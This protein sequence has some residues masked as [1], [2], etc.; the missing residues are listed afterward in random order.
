M[1][2][3]VGLGVILAGVLREAARR[4]DLREVFS[5]LL[6]SSTVA[7][8]ERSSTEVLQAVVDLVE[9]RDRYTRGHSARVAEL[10]AVIGERLGLYPEH[11]RRL[12]Q[13]AVLHDVGK[14]AVP[15]MI[16]NKPGPL[17]AEEFAV[18]AAHTVVGDQLI[19][20]IPALS[21]AR[22]GI[23]WH[24]ERLDG[25]GYP[26][27][28]AGDAIPLEA[29]IIAVADVYD[30]MTSTRAYR[31]GLGEK[32]ALDELRHHAGVK[33]DARAVGA[34]VRHIEAAAASRG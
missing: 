10:S 18:V 9:A 31:P 14:I 19:E 23:R 21:F 5:V 6:A 20:R 4:H 28:L 27:G 22:P 25:T 1:L 30:A 11:L 3:L 15:G 7:K 13:T 24:H 34:L 26:D 32:A 33:Y 8:L 29:R 17:T 2:L 12:Y 16:L